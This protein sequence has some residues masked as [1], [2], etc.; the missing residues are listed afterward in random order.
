MTCLLFLVESLSVWLVVEVGKVNV[1][2][3][4][5]G[6]QAT[7]PVGWQVEAKLVQHIDNPIFKDLLTKLFDQ[8]VNF[9]TSQAPSK[10][11]QFGRILTEI[12]QG[13][14]EEIFGLGD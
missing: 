3:D 11:G 5:I 10:L 13:E 6:D 7:S 8:A 4:E 14:F 12:L 9:K 1:E 2:C